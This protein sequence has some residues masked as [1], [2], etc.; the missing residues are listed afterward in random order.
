[1]ARGLLQNGEQGRTRARGPAR[2][3]AKRQR[4]VALMVA[5]ISIAVLTAVTTEF[6]Y[7]SR[8]D[9]QM[10]GNQ[11]DDIR[12]YYLAR[13]GIGMSRLLL[14]F[15]KQV[16]AIQLPPGLNELLGGALGGAVPGGAA[17]GQVP[18]PSGFNIQL[19]KLARIDCY[20]LQSMIVS[21]GDD[22]RSKV[23]ESL[24]QR[25]VEGA[26]DGEEVPGGQRDFG[27]FTGCF[28]VQIEAEEPKINLNA[29]EIPN[30]G[31]L[32]QA[33]AVFGDKQF[34]FLFEREDANRARVTPSELLINI[35]DWMDQDQVASAIQTDGL[36]AQ[37]QPG[38]SD[39]NRDY[40]RYDPRY[41]AKNARFD[42]LDEVFMVHGVNDRM[43]AVFRDRFTVY[44]DPNRAA[45][46]NTDDPILL[47]GAILRA[48][49]PTKPDPRLRDP[50]FIAQLIQAIQT[51]KM[52]SFLG[53]S[54]KDFIAVLQSQG[55]QVRGDFAGASGGNFLS[56]KNSTFTIKATGEAGAIKKTI[57]AVVR[58][59]RGQL[60]QLVYW[61][62]E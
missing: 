17:A 40:S 61:R 12:A 14:S 29:L 51:A 45:N 53:M 36:R 22:A 4:G 44:G 13:S 47:W 28:D 11:R 39:E 26:E 46:I 59:D 19:W 43:M 49:D 9:L 55:V 41:Q 30:N 56:D 48:A 2:A 32:E 31:V 58:M 27:S 37:F 1:M 21:D 52:F 62:E 8:V 18:T 34:E 7:S 35:K 54:T 57:T 6:L 3:N 25:R 50:L 15:Q 33:L 60:G 20:L 23:A 16:D 10:A 38:F 42:S 5:L 24:G